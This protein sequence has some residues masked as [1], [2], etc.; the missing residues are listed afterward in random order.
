MEKVRAAG[1]L[2]ARMVLFLIVFFAF[3]SS[4]G[5]SSFSK[6]INY[7]GKLTNASGV[8][9]SDGSYNMEFKLYTASTGGSSIWSNTLIQNDRISVTNGLF[10]VLLGA[11]STSFAS[12]NFDQ[13]LY[14]SINIGGTTNTATPTW[15]GEMT[16]RK[17]FSP[18]PFAFESD[19]IDGLDS[20]QFARNDTTNQSL[21][22]T[23]STTTNATTTNLYI[24]G[25]SYVGG[26]AT[27]TEA[28]NISTRGTLLVLGSTTLQNFTAVNST[29]TNATSTSFYASNGS[30][31]S[32]IATGATTTTLAIS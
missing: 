27:T 23:N 13:P 3:S 9:V 4:A 7:Q 2:F 31:A 15:D 19:K 28:G 1:S 16:P 29:T 8:T 30:I 5:A 24:S 11:T 12:I 14:M 17:Q 18:A 25:M 10:S 20:T 22:V 21:V 6:I 32:L 26:N